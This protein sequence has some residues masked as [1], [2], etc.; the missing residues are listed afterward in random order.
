[1]TDEDARSRLN[2]LADF[3]GRKLAAPTERLHYGAYGT[4]VHVATND[5][6]ILDAARLAAGRYSRTSTVHAPLHLTV[7]HDP[8]L[9]AEPIPAN[10]PTHLR[11]LAVGRWQMI[12]REPWVFAAL[13]RAQQQAVAWISTPLMHAPYF[14]SRYVFDTLTLNTLIHTGVGQLHA[15]CLYRDNRAILFAA[16]HNTGKSTTSFRLVHRGYR[17]LADGMSYVRLTARGFE[18]MGYPVGEVKLRR[19]VLDQFPALTGR[20]RALLVREDKKMIYNL[21]AT[22]PDRVCEESVFPEEIVICLLE[23]DGQRE[24]VATPIDAAMALDGLWLDAAHYDDRA[25]IERNLSALQALLAHARCYRLN[26]GTDTTALVET[27]DGL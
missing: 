18:L 25:I 12:A 23:R 21:R 11:Y 14:L 1:M 13:D 26:I 3:W 4:P 22:M 16:P 17:I 15:S 9:P 20:G 6:L 19:D 8:R 27:V 2:A 5:P 10:W 7:I 24:T